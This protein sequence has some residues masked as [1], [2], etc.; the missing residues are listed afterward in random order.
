MPLV[1]HL[2]VTLTDFRPAVWRR[3]RVPSAVTLGE[4]GDILRVAF[5]WGGDHLHLF[6][7]D[8]VRYGP[9]PLLEGPDL[10]HE[11]SVRLIEVLPRPGAAL[12]YIYDLGDEWRHL[13]EVED[14]VPAEPDARYP[15]CVGGA[16]KAPEE[17]SYEPYVPGAF[18]PGTVNKALDGVAGRDLP[19]GLDEV[20]AAFTGLFPRLAQLE[21]VLPERETSPVSGLAEPAAGSQLVRRALALADWA[22][23]GRA[24]TPSGLPRPAEALQAEIEL[25]LAAPVLPGEEAGSPPGKVKSAKDLPGLGV[26]WPAAV[27]AGLVEVRGSKAVAG[28]AVRRWEEGDAGDRVEV[29]ASLLGGV[30]RA[31]TRGGR[32]DRRAWARDDAREMFS[33]TVQL[34]DQLPDQ[35][36][37]VLLPALVIGAA[38]G[39]GRPEG[40]A[41]AAADAM[42]VWALAGVIEPTG[43]PADPDVAESLMRELLDDYRERAPGL[44]SPSALLREILKPTLAV[45]RAGAAVRLT[46]L[47]A[48]GV[49]RILVA[50]GWG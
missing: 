47:G 45:V 15:V 6:D 35:P 20:D 30:L 50:Q 9:D 31:R 19:E 48:Y 16:E 12:H 43:D 26:L 8:H 5:E 22:G 36:F 2:K 34:L 42:G 32:S 7:A 13:V 41:R 21:V 1:H 11:D 23:S 4:L 27:E 10:F 3:L 37:P 38:S 46:A 33:I 14:I 49:R 29:W 44:V 18:D 39:Y 24:L 25:G 28:P 40:F 17:D